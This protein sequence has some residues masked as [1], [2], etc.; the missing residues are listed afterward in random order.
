MLLFLISELVL[1]KNNMWSKML[2]YT[3]SHVTCFLNILRV[4]EECLCISCILVIL[5]STLKSIKLWFKALH[6]SVICSWEI[7]IFV[8]RKT[9]YGLQMCGM[10][11]FN[12]T[13]SP[14][15]FSSSIIIF[16]KVQVQKFNFPFSN[17]CSS[18]Q[19]LISFLLY[20]Y[21]T[22]IIRIVADVFFQQFNCSIEL[23][24]FVDFWNSFI[25]NLLQLILFSYCFIINM[26]EGVIYFLSNSGN[27][28]LTEF[29]ILMNLLQLSAFI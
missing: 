20:L 25:H 11:A 15:V 14:S 18:V 4:I 9:L 29:E 17:M 28:F 1:F 2:I 16:L 27:I 7:I 10:I 21:S 26:T 19:N 12:L 22:S 6:F 24:V 3:H 5:E 13:L 8:L 23:S